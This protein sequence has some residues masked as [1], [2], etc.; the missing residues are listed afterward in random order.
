[1]TPVVPSEL[2]VFGSGSVPS[3]APDLHTRRSATRYSDVTP[4]DQSCPSLASGA[5]LH[6][7]QL[8]GLPANGGPESVYLISLDC[9]PDV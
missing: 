6:W 2:R 7:T 4:D 1:M 8:E 5:R 9:I 3:K